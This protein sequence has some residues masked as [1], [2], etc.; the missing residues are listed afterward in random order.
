MERVIVRSASDIQSLAGYKERVRPENDP[1]KRIVQPYHVHIAMQCALCGHWH[2]DGYIVE[3]ERGGVTNIGHICGRK[4]WDTF[5]AAEHDYRERELRPKL[6]QKLSGAAPEIKALSPVSTDLRDRAL[7]LGRRK[8]EFLHRFPTLSAELRR[9]ANTNRTQVMRIQERDKATIDEMMAANPR[10]DRE[11]LQYEEIPVGSLQ[12]LPLFKI[13]LHE[14]AVV[15]FTAR[16]EQFLD[17]DTTMLPTERLVDWDTW[18][19][20][21]QQRHQDAQR[22]VIEGELFF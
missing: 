20:A 3:L 16:V 5:S 9:R 22:A 17:M 7:L 12:G 2:N 8:R 10:Q 1:F 11:R 6:L 18:I 21:L 19:D 13:K 14:T 15:N 4:S